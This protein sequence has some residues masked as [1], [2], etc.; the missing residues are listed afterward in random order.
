[1]RS[2]RESYTTPLSVR[3]LLQHAPEVGRPVGSFCWS[4][5]ACKSMLASDRSYLPWPGPP[6]SPAWSRASSRVPCNEVGGEGLANPALSSRP[7]DGQFWTISEK[8]VNITDL[9]SWSGAWREMKASNV[10]R[11][12]DQRMLHVPKLKVVP[13]ASIQEGEKIFLRNSRIN[14]IWFGIER[15]KAV[16]L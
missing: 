1:M 4:V 6:R 16:D 10:K 5:P 3:A 2:Q 13:V 11:L 12:C 7:P 15:G 8:Q 9:M 14:R